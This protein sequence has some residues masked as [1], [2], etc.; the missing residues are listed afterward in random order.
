[1][2][3][4]GFTLAELM[5]VIA[6]I[7]ILSAVSLYGWRGYQDNVNL[8][9]AAGDVATD[10]AETK[11]RAV[12]EGVQYRITFNTAANNYIIEQGTSSG[13]PYTTVQT[14]S[15]TAFGAGSGLF[16]LS[17]NFSNSEV[18]F[19]TRGT[20]SPG[21]VILRNGKGSQATITINITGKTYVQFAMQ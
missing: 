4:K 7:G 21:T 2:S 5:I 14:K 15:P 13:T 8:R 19:Y 6:I 18:L 1:M 9:T 16:I 3:N 10:M 17:T 12:S 11:Q 20:I